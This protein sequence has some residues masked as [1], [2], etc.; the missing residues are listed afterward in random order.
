MEAPL[1]LLNDA[2]VIDA[3]WTNPKSLIGRLLKLFDREPALQHAVRAIASVPFVESTQKELSARF[4]QLRTLFRGWKGGS[5]A[6]LP[7]L[8]DLMC[9]YAYTKVFFAVRDQSTAVSVVGG[10]G[11][12]SV[13]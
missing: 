4:L 5:T 13:G 3:V 9:M 12:A 7:A 2:E 6:C 8:A 1:R 11:M 10:G